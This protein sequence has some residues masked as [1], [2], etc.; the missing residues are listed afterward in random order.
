MKKSDLDFIRKGVRFDDPFFAEKVEMKQRLLDR[1]SH[2]GL[3][4]PVD[5]RKAFTQSVN[6]FNARLNKNK[7]A[8]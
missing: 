3:L 5:L 2:Q 8:D 1:A 7:E 6:D 4:K